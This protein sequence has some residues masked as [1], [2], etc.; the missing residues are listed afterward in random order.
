MDESTP[1]KPNC[2]DSDIALI[3]LQSL[4]DFSDQYYESLSALFEQLQLATYEASDMM[5]G[6]I[7]F[8]NSVQYF[9]VIVKEEFKM[10]S[11]SSSWTRRELVRR[12]ILGMIY[13]TMPSESRNNPIG[14]NDLNI[15]I[16]I[17]PEYRRKGYATRALR[18][19]LDKAFN[20]IRCHR[21]QAIIMNPFT[22]AKY[23]SY[24]LFT[25][26]GFRQEGIR[27]SSYFNPFDNEY[28]DI[29]YLA[30][31]DTEWLTTHQHSN[32]HM[33]PWDEVLRRHEHE[34]G[35]IMRWEERIG[36]A[37]ET[38]TLHQFAIDSCAAEDESTSEAGSS[39][40]QSDQSRA[41]SRVTSPDL[42][43]DDTGESSFASESFSSSPS[44]RAPSERPESPLSSVD[45]NWDL[46]DDDVADIP[47]GVL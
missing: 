41:T 20:E 38:E 45:S 27:R 3:D 14:V 29:A 30:I 5:L 15:G 21:V 39:G 9:A 8:V 6:F 7:A 35:M 46:M 31:L 4:L 37:D 10:T 17:Y 23:S 1:P 26:I 18:L 25:S 13:L 24:R 16:I 44:S 32:P 42:Y 47:E 2:Q 22:G 36:D 40:D 34:R 33:T 12:D 43:I 11:R 19:V 28:Q